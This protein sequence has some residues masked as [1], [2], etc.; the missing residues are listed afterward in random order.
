MTMAYISSDGAISV[1]SYTGDDQWEVKKINNT[2]IIGRNAV[3]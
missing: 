3:S 2:H 1:L